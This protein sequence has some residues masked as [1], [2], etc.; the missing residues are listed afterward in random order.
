MSTTEILMLISM[1]LINGAALLGFFITIKIKIAQMEVKI[2]NIYDE[3][4]EY[5]K[6]IKCQDTKIDLK[7]DKI[8]TKLDIL[9]SKIVEILINLAK[10]NK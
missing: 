8:D 9:N 1:I 3:L 4:I 6:R 7:F 5:D 10:I 2:C